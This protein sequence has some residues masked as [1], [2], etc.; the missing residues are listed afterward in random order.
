MYTEKKNQ[1]NKLKELKTHTHT[2]THAPDSEGVIQTAKD[3]T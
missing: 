3:N 2:H 1:R